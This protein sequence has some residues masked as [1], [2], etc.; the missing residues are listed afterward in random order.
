MVYVMSDIHGNMTRFDSILKQINLQPTDE[1]Y[2]LGDV[3]D[4]YPDGIKIL[5]RVMA[6]PNAHM[7]LGNHEYMMMNAI[8]PLEV[9]TDGY[10]GNRSRP[11]ALRL[12]YRNGG[13]VTHEYIKRIR[14]T[15]RR[16]IFEY[17]HALPLNLEVEVNGTKFVLVHGG[18][19][20]NFDTWLLDWYSDK[21]QYAVW[22][23]Q[24]L[25][26]DPVEGRVMI[27]GHTPTAMYCHEPLLSI[28]HCRDGKRIGID[29]GGGYP[30]PPA[31]DDSPQFGRLACLR[32]DDMKEF[33]SDDGGFAD[34][35][36]TKDSEN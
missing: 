27:F 8:A 5:R 29:C 35:Q 10:W 16:E 3:I 14:K 21:R 26:D 2:I 13:D 28:W 36:R 32:L 18:A 24:R 25:W 33:Y 1:L 12:W 30:P 15:V 11:D 22:F 23:R 9:F 7:L 31:W 19:E 20:A 6:M 34:A 17:I 4:R